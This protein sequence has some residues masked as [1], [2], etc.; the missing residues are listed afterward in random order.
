MSNRID[1]SIQSHTAC[2]AL[3]EELTAES[4]GNDSASSTEAPVSS[5]YDCVN[6]CVS[7]VGLP[8]LAASAVSALGCYAAPPTCPILIGGAAGAVIGWCDAQCDPDTAVAKP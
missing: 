8:Q 4:P 7:S 6:D 3:E 5:R 2:F 1:C